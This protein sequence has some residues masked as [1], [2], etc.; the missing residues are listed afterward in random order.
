[1]S[2]LTPGA[3]LVGRALFSPSAMLSIRLPSAEDADAFRRRVLLT[4]VLAATVVI[5]G[6]GAMLA[7]SQ[8]PDAAP[9]QA[10]GQIEDVSYEDATPLTGRV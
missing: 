3:V 7:V 4:G 1:M 5:G 9:I 8:S 2:S 6:A 10:T